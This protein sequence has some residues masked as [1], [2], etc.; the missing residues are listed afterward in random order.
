MEPAL[1]TSAELVGTMDELTV[2]QFG[3]VMIKG[4]IFHRGMVRKL[5]L[6]GCVDET[7]ERVRGGLRSQ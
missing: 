6:D 1:F 5:P 7:G 4:R 2:L 3:I